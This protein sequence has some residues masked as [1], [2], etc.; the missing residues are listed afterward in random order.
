MTKLT[1]GETFY[2]KHDHSPLF[3]EQLVIGETNR[4]WIVTGPG[5]LASWQTPEDYG[6][7]L[8]KSGKGW[9]LGT[10]RDKELYAWANQHR[11]MIGNA[12]NFATPE[13]LR[14]IADMIGYKEP[15]VES[16]PS[17]KVGY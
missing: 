15:F 8:P 10:K 5:G 16:T 17:C 2:I 4:S 3:W 11:W 12:V 1:V 6:T 13:Q 9:T 14:T 7:K